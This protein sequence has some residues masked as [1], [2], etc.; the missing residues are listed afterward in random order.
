MAPFQQVSFRLN[1]E[2]WPN[3]RTGPRWAGCPKKWSS[4]GL[5][6]PLSN[7]VTGAVPERARNKESKFGA[8]PS[9]DL[10]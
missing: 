1:Q 4:T 7:R 9:S 10:M 2:S 3:S 5:I 6:A 8:W